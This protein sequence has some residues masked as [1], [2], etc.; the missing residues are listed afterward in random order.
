MIIKMVGQLIVQWTPKYTKE[1]CITHTI[2][3]QQLFGKY[4][5]SP[6]TEQ[7][8]ELPGKTATELI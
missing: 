5:A 2:Q 8:T 6:V 7:E 3:I 1:R 4:L